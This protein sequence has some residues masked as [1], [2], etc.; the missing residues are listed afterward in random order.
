M[1]AQLAYNRTG[2]LAPSDGKDFYLRVGDT[3]ILTKVQI[4]SKSVQGSIA[5]SLL[6]AKSRTL[7]VKA[8]GLIDRHLY[9]ELFTTWLNDTEMCL[10]RVENP[11]GMLR[12]R[13]TRR[14]SS[15]SQLLGRV[16]GSE[17]VAEKEAR[18]QQEANRKG[19]GQTIKY[20]QS[21]LLRHINS[22]GLLSLNSLGTGVEPGTWEV[23][24]SRE[25]SPNYFTKI[26]LSPNNQLQKP[27]ESIKYGDKLN[28]EFTAENQQY[29]LH[30]SKSTQEGRF[31]VNASHLRSDWEFRKYESHLLNR[32]AIR[33]GVPVILKLGR[34]KMMVTEGFDK[35]EPV[36]ITQRLRKR[37][38]IQDSGVNLESQS[39][40]LALET[41]SQSAFLS[42]SVPK[43][44]L[45]SNSASNLSLSILSGLSHITARS[46]VKKLQLTTEANDCG[47][48]WILEKAVP[49]QGGAL[50][51][52]DRFYLKNVKS[53]HYVTN[54]SLELKPEPNPDFAFLVVK[55]ESFQGSAYVPVNYPIIIKSSDH[56]FLS[57]A[58]VVSEEEYM[59]DIVP[60]RHFREGTS[61]T[62]ESKLGLTEDQDAENPLEITPMDEVDY[63]FF[64]RVAKLIPKVKEVRSLV[65]SWMDSKDSLPHLNYV[66]KEDEI[67]NVGYNFC[68]SLNVLE[69]MLEESV[70]PEM[71]AKQ[72]CN[73]VGLGLTSQLI[74]LASLLADFS[75]L[76]KRSEELEDSSFVSVSLQME[77]KIWLFLRILAENLPFV[78]ETL[79]AQD[80][81]MMNLLHLRKEL[82]GPVLTEVYRVLDPEIKD[83]KAFFKGWIDRIGTVTAQNVID[84]TVF[85]E[86][87]KNVCEVDDMPK[88]E[89]Q[90]ALIALLYEEKQF[91]LLKF[92][93]QQDSFFV[94]F[95]ASSHEDFLTQN[96]ELAFYSQTAQ[97]G[98]LVFKLQDLTFLPLYLNYVQGA[99]GLITV[100]CKGKV[101][102][103]REVA[104]SKQ[105]LAMDAE[106]IFALLTL[107][108][109]HF[110]VVQAL[111]DLVQATVL[112][113]PPLVSFRESEAENY[114]YEEE[115][116][117][118]LEQM[119]DFEGTFNPP[120][121]NGKILNMINASLAFWLSPGL[122]SLLHKYTKQEVLQP[123][124]STLRFTYALIEYNH[125]SSLFT[126]LISV[127][128]A[129]IL[130]GFSGERGQK[131]VGKHWVV[132]V[133]QGLVLERVSGDVDTEVMEFFKQVIETVDLIQLKTKRYKLNSVVAFF[134]ENQDKDLQVDSP[135][136][137]QL[138]ARLKAYSA[139][140]IPQIEEIRQLLGLSL[141]EAQASVATM[142]KRPPPLADYLLYSV[143]NLYSVPSD[144]KGAVIRTLEN[145]FNEECL[146]LTEVKKTEL[147]RGELAAKSRLL[148]LKGELEPS[149]I[150]TKAKTELNERRTLTS[151]QFLRKVLF[152]LVALLRPTAAFATTQ[153]IL[154][155]LGFHKTIIQLWPL[156]NRLDQEKELT[157][158][159]V[160]LA[161]DFKALLVSFLACFARHN[162]ANQE[163][164]L[165]VL[166]KKNFTLDFP[167]YAELIFDLTHF[168]HMAQGKL[169]KA[170]S[171]I[172]DRCA[173]YSSHTDLNAH[174]F[175]RL[176]MLSPER[177]ELSSMQNIIARYI[178]EQYRNLPEFDISEEN[179]YKDV[180]FLEL[181]SRAAI[182]NP[183]I[184]IMCREIIPF[185]QLEVLFE[186]HSNPAVLCSLL[187]FLTYVYLWPVEDKGVKPL[188]PF[189]IL[190]KVVDKLHTTLKP[191]FDDSA[192]LLAIGKKNSYEL[193][194]E[195]GQ[196]PMVN[197]N[198]AREPFEE[199]R[200]LWQLL[201]FQYIDDQR[202]GG[203]L[204]LVPW[205]FKYADS[206]EKLQS[207]ARTVFEDVQKLQSSLYLCSEQ[208]ICVHQLESAIS[209]FNTEVLRC[210][211]GLAEPSAAVMMGPRSLRNLKRMPSY[212][213]ST[214][215]AN[216]R[217]PHFQELFA[218]A[219]SSETA[220][221]PST[222]TKKIARRFLR[223]TG[224]RRAKGTVRK[225]D[226]EANIINLGRLHRLFTQTPHS[227]EYFSIL[228]HILPDDHQFKVKL[229]NS[230]IKS[231]VIDEAVDELLQLSLSSAN[232]ALMF[233]NKLLYEQDLA[234]QRYFQTLVDR[235]ER[236]YYLFSRIKD[237]LHNAKSGILSKVGLT[238][239]GERAALS[240]R[241][242]FLV[243]SLKF[244][245]LCCDNCNIDFQ[246]YIRQQGNQIGKADVDLVSEVAQFLI[247]IQD[248]AKELSKLIGPGKIIIKAIGALLDFVTGPCPENQERLGNNV[249]LFQAV[250]RFV[251]VTQMELDEISIEIHHNI[252]AFLLTLLEKTPD[253][254][255]PLTMVKFLDLKVLREGVEKIYSELV[256]GQEEDMY[257]E[258]RSKPHMAKIRTAIL[259]AIVLLK[260][261]KYSSHLELKKFMTEG[262]A[263]Y[264]FYTS[265]IG[266]VQ[267]DCEGSIEE[268]YF[269]VPFMCKFLTPA[270]RQSI[271]FDINRSSHQSKIEDFLDKVDYY[272]TEM[273]HQQH[274]SQHRWLKSLSKLWKLYAQLSYIMV[275]LLNGLLLCTLTGTEEKTVETYPWLW[276][277]LLCLGLMQLLLYVASFI[278]NMIEYFPLRLRNT[279]SYESLEIDKYSSFPD[280]ES[281]LLTD[282]FKCIE[283]ASRDTTSF[284]NSLR[285]ITQNLDFYY[286]FIYLL[287]A[288]LGLY[289]PLIYPILLLD[290]IKQNQELVN[291]LRS[292]TVNLRQL[293][294]TLV[295]G[296]I[297]IF[298]FSVHS[299]GYFQKYYNP[300]SNADCSTLYNCFTSTL[301]FGIRAGGGIGDGL[302]PATSEDYWARMAFD[303]LYYVIMIIIL[304]NIIFGIIID[305]FA[306]LRDER[307]QM[308]HDLS[309]TCF[310]CGSSRSEIELKGKGWSYHF[311]CE[312]SP[313]S[314]LAFFVFLQETNIVDCSGVEKYVKEKLTAKDSSFMPTTSKLLQMKA[315]S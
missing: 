174:H 235:S 274:L 33:C 190:S 281:Y 307:S 20:G 275:L 136:L 277:G 23:L 114:C 101:S 25:S 1:E 227:Q 27:G 50:L 287:V 304:L 314:Y 224:L 19:L 17:E 170:I 251:K 150:I 279:G 115:K 36:K 299:F 214:I 242:I 252:I 83:V 284:K 92:Y 30:V 84:Q 177:K 76:P 164:L 305:T 250:N 229:N 110:S 178:A 80:R 14:E 156:I 98:A 168:T 280:N 247:D 2:S 103:G 142:L 71:H 208:G 53:G 118:T 204:S 59:V 222:F 207:Q 31:E 300:E 258:L 145:S 58:K 130:A 166:E 124:L 285:N 303:L 175:L 122:P 239:S 215:T 133:V 311:M 259:Q 232:A 241:D 191:L 297:I 185:G 151:L 195:E 123:V 87:I 264:E 121:L 79:A 46:L 278:F 107:Q 90:R 138:I 112:T 51:W 290:I 289:E 120:G 132:E 254:S 167:E 306:Q 18:V 173:N 41:E 57:P 147:L 88:P 192:Q 26:T 105:G 228:T 95:F 240:E 60:T 302:D 125:T 189:S 272:H 282:T 24:V 265:N 186:K 140:E 236:S 40:D 219:Y 5:A 12:G 230:Y 68:S 129:Y 63:L 7:A 55:P 268:L 9:G 286:N 217:F 221:K 54:S 21:I 139:S 253:P 293:L 66:E 312:H 202:H 104:V 22:E 153:N 127:V 206:P 309:N 3:V 209:S 162:S 126:R 73:I 100:L 8:E 38:G 35:L 106:D 39:A 32:E 263:A 234:F 171:N 143:F 163:A 29:L 91:F 4:T 181:L 82:V 161:F 172:V 97:D 184:T 137:A 15:F 256:K 42:R 74:E 102:Q 310:V 108:Q 81:V 37:T 205:V 48:V 243:R 196:W 200:N 159:N 119:S 223:F 298:L 44:R 179:C 148:E 231:G 75:T 262:S 220:F 267:V 216:A 187:S 308:A 201:C 261:K 78:C 134:T 13:I 270:S 313:F 199:G 109:V 237:E 301:Y 52:E 45:T 116:V 226:I 203:F 49:L 180:V 273:Q 111:V 69:R 245:Q 238:P 149:D 146:F 244:L 117:G 165:R 182:Q 160:L 28:I 276:I 288:V 56:L 96:P 249:L 141:E 257:R 157:E 72:R 6:S 176:M 183:S 10:F 64:M 218:K 47:V 144:L 233:L 197:V 193:V 70:S 158:E 34:R 67:K 65:S 86:L 294:L 93:K 271:I 315:L 11:L 266:Y 128:L 225:E 62:Y 155:N 99:L 169:Q 154:R 260:L 194:Y 188:N 211:P 85:F 291:I 77:Q 210:Y 292:I 296:L 152:E 113:T 16:S 255:V 131:F 212:G 61:V 283:L 135:E 246:N 198:I 94:H 295:L 89:Y 269:P 248:K 43:G 213:V